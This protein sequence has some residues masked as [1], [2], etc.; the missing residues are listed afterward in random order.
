MTL[1]GEPVDDLID[2]MASHYPNGV[3]PFQPYDHWLEERYR[4]TVHDGTI[5]RDHRTLTRV[6]AVIAGC[7]VALGVT[8]LFHSLFRLSY[9]AETENK[10]AKS[11]GG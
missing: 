7:I 3:I 9:G 4:R 11:A 5:P 1:K 8:Y 6:A 2:N 10:S